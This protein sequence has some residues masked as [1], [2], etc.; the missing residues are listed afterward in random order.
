M[1]TFRQKND[2]KNRIVRPGQRAPADEL[3]SGA[4]KVTLEEAEQGSFA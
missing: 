2:K 1:P 3:C 4:Y